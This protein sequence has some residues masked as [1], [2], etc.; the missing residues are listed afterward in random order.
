ML[1]TLLE[2][3]NAIVSIH[4]LRHVSLREETVRLEHPVQTRTRWRA[5]DLRSSFLFLVSGNGI[6]THLSMVS[7][8]PN[9][10]GKL[11]L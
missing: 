8:E 10:P 2:Y 6:K 4:H 7:S 9:T 11:D 3:K 5:K 1:G